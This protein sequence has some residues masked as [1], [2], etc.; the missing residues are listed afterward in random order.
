MVSLGKVGGS[1]GSLRLEVAPVSRGEEAWD[2]V[3]R[4]LD[5]SST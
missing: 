1:S 5:D 2:V 4:G 3:V